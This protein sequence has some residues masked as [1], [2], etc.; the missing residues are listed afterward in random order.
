M[1]GKGIK[2]CKTTDLWI[3]KNYYLELFDEYIEDNYG[4][5]EAKMLREYADDNDDVIIEMAETTKAEYQKYCSG[6]IDCLFKFRTKWNKKWIYIPY[7]G[8]SAFAMAMC[9]ILPED[10]DDESDD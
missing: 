9:Y 8:S 4:K 5:R 7:C 3:S 2:E 1:C 6:K 10:C